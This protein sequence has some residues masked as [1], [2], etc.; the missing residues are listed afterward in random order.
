MSRKSRHQHRSHP[1]IATP[2]P[3]AA[4]QS[5]GPVPIVSPEIEVVKLV[6][7]LKAARLAAFSDKP[8]PV[9]TRPWLEPP[10][11]AQAVRVAA[12]RLKSKFI[13]PP[14]DGDPALMAMA[15]QLAAFLCAYDKLDDG[16]DLA[17]AE[18]KASGD[19]TPQG[20]RVLN[21]A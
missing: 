15:Q 19:P 16:A 10:G 8:T 2:L 7:D 18:A 14:D 1:L 5:D 20:S 6:E 4:I 17:A 21:A 11:W 3:K 13:V 12:A 9:E